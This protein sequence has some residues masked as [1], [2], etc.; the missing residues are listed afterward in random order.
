VAFIGVAWHDTEDHHSQF[1]G[2]HGLD[3][4]P[5]VVDEDESLFTR[6]GFFYQPSFVFIDDDGAVVETIRAELS[7]EELAARLDALIAR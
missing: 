7:E 5:H 2:R 6:F 4:F 3:T 1:V